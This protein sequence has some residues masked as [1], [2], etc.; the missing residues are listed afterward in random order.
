MHQFACDDN[1]LCTT[2]DHC[3]LGQC[4]GGADLPCDDGNSCTD[5]SCNSQT[6]CTFTPNQEGCDDGDKCTDQ[7]ECSQ[8]WC[9]GTVVNCDDANVCTDDS[10]DP[11]TGCVNTPNQAPCSDDDPCT[12]GDSCLNSACQPGENLNCSDSNPCTDDLCD[13]QKGCVYEN[14]SANC[15]DD[16]E[17]T[18][19]DWC[20]QGEC[21][22]GP[23]ELDCDDSD[24]KTVDTCE[25][26][27]GCKHTASQQVIYSESFIQGQSSS[28]Q[29]TAFHTFRAKLTGDSYTKIT[30]RGTF[31]PTGVSCTGATANSLCKAMHNDASGQW[32]CDGRTWAW[33]KIS[34]DDLTANGSDGSCMSPAYT[35]RPCIGNV[36]WGGADTP[37]CGAP[38]QTLEVICE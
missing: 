2:G 9:K 19:G 16:D 20:D 13:E 7:D 31:A 21:Q 34:C 6:G 18:V 10:C 30:I 27:E 38:S 32:S 12:M 23:D 28:S 37:S 25:P 14:N 5:D 22:P 35:V 24:P 33:D 15:D 36:N 1:D 26:L 4:M 11:L 3:H 17:C 29:C 8:G